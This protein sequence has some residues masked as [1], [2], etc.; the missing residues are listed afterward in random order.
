MGF[1]TG[2]SIR[3][4]LPVILGSMRWP[5]FCVAFCNTRGMAFAPPPADCFPGH[6]VWIVVNGKYFGAG[7]CSARLGGAPVGIRRRN[8][9]RTPG[10]IVPMKR[11]IFLLPCTDTGI[12]KPFY[13]LP[14]CCLP[15]WMSYLNRCDRGAREATYRESFPVG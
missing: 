4:S 9:I 10:S 3:I 15:L 13:P 8:F 14:R 7:L 5:Y 12:G 6:L 11:I 2:G 1:D